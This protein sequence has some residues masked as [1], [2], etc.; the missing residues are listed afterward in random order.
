MTD[1]VALWSTP[2]AGIHPLIWLLL[3]L[4]VGPPM[5]LSKITARIPGIFGATARWWQS[6]DPDTLSY[7]KQQ[8]E[9][10]R[11]AEQYD[12]LHADYKAQQQR[13]DAL[14][15]RQAETDRILSEE[16]SRLSQTRLHLAAAITYIR[17]LTSLI[18]S[19]LMPAAP[20]E[21]KEH[22]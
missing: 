3:F 13:I 20:P 21:L 15:A 2:I 10:A 1:D 22:L 7:E 4:A 19:E 11:I 12:R 18:P 5:L 17:Q 9:I 8:Q 6:R 16:R 14:E